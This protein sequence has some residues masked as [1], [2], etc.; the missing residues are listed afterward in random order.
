MTA[1]SQRSLLVLIGAVLFIV[2]A[3]GV[4]W[5]LSLRSGRPFGHTQ[6][7]HAIGWVGFACILVACV[8]PIKKRFRRKPGW[9]RRAF[10][11][12]M[13]F[14]VLG[15]VLIL[16]HSGTHFHAAV[17]MAAMLAMAVVVLSGVVG[18]AL[19]YAAFREVNDHRRDLAERGLSDTAIEAEIHS[20][21]HREEALRLW[22][23]IHGPVTAVFV[24][25]ALMHIGAAWYFGG[26]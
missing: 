5:A 13:I 21:V 8:Y 20:L 2:V 14:G 12:H 26:P 10:R 17:P 15:P 24:V 3:F 11:A 22:Q 9:S 19:H 23:C 6:S 4:E 18:Q 1:L 25:L 16:V 7:G